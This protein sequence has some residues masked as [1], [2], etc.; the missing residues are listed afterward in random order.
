MAGDIADVT[1]HRLQGLGRMGSHI[2]RILRLGCGE[3]GRE[4]ETQNRAEKMHSLRM[5][6]VGILNPKSDFPAAEHCF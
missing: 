5:I 1:L 4:N 3:S 2:R 6:H